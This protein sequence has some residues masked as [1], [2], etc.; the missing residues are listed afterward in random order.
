MEPIFVSKIDMRS[1]YHHIQIKP[2]DEWKTAFKTN[3]G[4]FEWLVMPFR[5]SNAPSNFMRL[6]TQVLQPFI[7][8]FIVF[9]FD[10]ILIYNKQVDQHFGHLKKVFEVLRANTLYVNLKKCTFMVEKLLFLEFMIGSGGI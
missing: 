7:G 2:S 9:Y 10:D 1:G 4:L 3:E 8:K 5:F 6:V